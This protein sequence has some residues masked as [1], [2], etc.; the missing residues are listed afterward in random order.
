MSTI[1]SI[2][3]SVQKGFLKDILVGAGVTLGSMSV[4]YIVFNSAIDQYREEIM[5]VEKDLL[6]L[7]HLAGFDVLLSN[8]LAAILVSLTLRH[9]KLGLKKL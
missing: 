1:T 9:T 5:S 3:H 2:L 4:S 7:A 8:I 6:S